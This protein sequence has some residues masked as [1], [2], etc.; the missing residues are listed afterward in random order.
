MYAI[1]IDNTFIINDRLCIGRLQA[2]DEQ[3]ATWTVRSQVDEKRPTVP[4]G[5][6]RQSALSFRDMPTTRPSDFPEADSWPAS[7][8]VCPGT[9]P[10]VLG[11]TYEMAI[12]RYVSEGL[13]AEWL[14]ILLAPASADPD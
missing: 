9:E 7:M 12:S 11:I 4:S 8:R 5:A 6:L 13:V 1:L 3:S 14:E 10:A 2:D